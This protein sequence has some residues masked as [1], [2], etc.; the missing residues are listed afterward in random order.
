MAE[1]VARH[2]IDRKEDL[3]QRAV[4]DRQNLSK[5]IQ[6]LR[7]RPDLI[8]F[9]YTVSD[10]LFRTLSLV[11]PGCYRPETREAARFSVQTAV[12][13]YSMATAELE[14]QTD[15][16]ELKIGSEDIAV[17]AKLHA[18]A[19]ANHWLVAFWW[20]IIARSSEATD[21]LARYPLDRLRGPQSSD[22]LDWI[23]IL[24]SAWLNG[25]PIATESVATNSTNTQSTNDKLLESL[26][27]VLAAL[28]AADRAAFNRELMRALELHRGYFD[29][30]ANRGNMEGVV[31]IPL[32][33]LACWAHDRGVP[34]DVESDYAPNFFI[35]NSDWAKALR[36]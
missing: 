5:I 34:I 6:T 36:R 33:G 12:A 14:G 1:T 4:I 18:M 29:T 23:Q 32:L 11:D 26:I 20:S 30:D 8:D 2:R 27:N 17:A 9:S 19:D 7:S 25:L 21:M 28:A 3:E 13:I 22:L 31:S 15:K 10:S 24:C 35:Q 16:I